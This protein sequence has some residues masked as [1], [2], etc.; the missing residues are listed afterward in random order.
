MRVHTAAP[1]P[2]GP[3]AGG[4]GLSEGTRER[5]RVLCSALALAVCL[6]GPSV[7]DQV[8]L[9]L[10]ASWG[11][12]FAPRVALALAATVNSLGTLV[13]K[14][15]VTSA[16][17]IGEADVAGAQASG[18]SGHYRIRARHPSGAW[19]VG[20]VRKVRGSARKKERGRRCWGVPCPTPPPLSPTPHNP[21][22]PPPAT[23]L[24]PLPPLQ[25]ALA[26]GDWVHDVVFTLDAAGGPRNIEVRPAVAGGFAGCSG[27]AGRALPALG[28]PWRTRFGVVAFE[29]VVGP[30]DGAFKGT[31]FPGQKEITAVDV[32]TTQLNTNGGVV[33]EASKAALASAAA[34]EAAEAEGKKSWWERLQGYALP[35]LIFFVLQRMFD[36]GKEDRK[37]PAAGA[38]AAAQAAAK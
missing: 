9:E 27:A 10:E 24:L 12:P 14:P 25:C 4:G 29:D 31:P 13:W 1:V 2:V 34:R 32:L 33:D 5:M 30:T 26:A 28:A 37:A 15:N 23:A 16:G 21:P 17:V 11:G 18:G 8:S 7:G 6:G 22:P 20:S 19:V 3:L 36:G 38:G 35:I